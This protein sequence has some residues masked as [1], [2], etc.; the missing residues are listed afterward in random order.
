MRTLRCL[1]LMAL[2]ALPAAAMAADTL[3]MAAS[4]S[5]Q[6]SGLLE[7]LKPLLRRETGIELTWVSTSSGKALEHGKHCKVDVL[8]MGDPDF[9]LKMI[10]EGIVVDRREIMQH[11]EGDPG[12]LIQYSVMTVNPARCP[13][14]R[15]ELAKRFTEWWACPSARNHIAAFRPGDRQL[16]YPNAP[17]PSR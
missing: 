10:E 4:A 13:K 5:V 14:T 16:F 17:P 1:L 3:M 7:Y 15:A 2:M 11:I 6:D 12:L 9:E 8:F